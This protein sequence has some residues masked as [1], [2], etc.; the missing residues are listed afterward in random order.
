MTTEGWTVAAFPVPETTPCAAAAPVEFLDPAAAPVAEVMPLA[1]FPTVPAAFPVP[2]ATSAAAPDT[3][4]LAGRISSATHANA[5]D[6]PLCVH[7]NV[8]APGVPV[9]LPLD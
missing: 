4:P 3:P 1:E 5:T 7:P 9:P 8:V 6:P 2:D